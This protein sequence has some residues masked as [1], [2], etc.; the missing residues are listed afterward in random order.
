MSLVRLS[1]VLGEDLLPHVDAFI[2]ALLRRAN[3]QA[4]YDYET[5]QGDEAIE[6]HWVIG[7]SSL[8]RELRMNTEV[9]RDKSQS[10]ELLSST[11]DALGAGLTKVGS[12]ETTTGDWTSFAE[13]MLE[14]A[15]GLLGYEYSEEIRISAASILPPLV[16]G[17][18]VSNRHSE[19]Y[20]S[21]VIG[22]LVGPL[23]NALAYEDQPEPLSALFS[24]TSEIALVAPEAFTAPDIANFVKAISNQIEG[25]KKQA[26]ELR[27]DTTIEVETLQ[28]CM[29]ASRSTL[30]Y[31]SQALK[32]FLKNVGPKFPIQGLFDVFRLAV[33]GALAVD[34]EKEWAYRLIADIVEYASPNAMLWTGSFLP[35]VKDGISSQS[36]PAIRSTQRRLRLAQMRGSAGSAHTPL[37]SPLWLMMAHTR[38]SIKVNMVIT[39]FTCGHIDLLQLG[40]LFTNAL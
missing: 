21:Q 17:F 32:A 4:E 14:L 24:A 18:K 27:E 3:L 20:N 16:R 11:A 19:G 13:T 22:A 26:Q 5:A 6:E 39:A 1:E 23:L 38:A 29:Q 25:F 31:V 35:L 12:N 28:Q 8:G 7:P 34:G 37:V 30:E 2:P 33:H 10:L 40:S 15:S 36:E 9:L